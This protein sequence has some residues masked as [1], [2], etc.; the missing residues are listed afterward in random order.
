MR[1]FLLTAVVWWTVSDEEPLRLALA[2]AG[3][4]LLAAALRLARPIERGTP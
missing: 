1:L 3:L 4:L 2:V